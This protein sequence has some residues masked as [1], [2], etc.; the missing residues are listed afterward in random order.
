M[1]ED[2][3]G[4]GETFTHFVIG[5]SKVDHVKRSKSMLTALA[6]GAPVVDPGWVEAS[7]QAG[8]FVDGMKHL[9]DC[10]RWV[11]ARCPSQMQLPFGSFAGADL[12]GGPEVPVALKSRWP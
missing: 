5:G 3:M 9:F 10:H 8:T 2:E 12:P 11:A 1:S 6:L 7:A 4:R